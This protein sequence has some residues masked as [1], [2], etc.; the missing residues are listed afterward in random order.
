MLLLFWSY[1]VVMNDLVVTE[2]SKS[3]SFFIAHKEFFI[4]FA[5]FTI[6]IGVVIYVVGISSRIEITDA[7]DLQY[8][9]VTESRKEMSI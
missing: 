4:S 7:S 8:L 3:G 6:I 5:I 2:E 9:Q 1:N